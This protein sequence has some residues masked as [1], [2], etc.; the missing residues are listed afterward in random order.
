M[1]ID[2][3]TNSIPTQTPIAIV[4]MDCLFPDAN[5]LKQYWRLIRRSED[6]V[7]DVPASHWSVDDYFDADLRTAD[8]T[9]CRRG[10]FLEPTDFDPLEFGIPPRLLEATDTAQ[11]LGLVV[12][13]RALANAG[14]GND[15]D[16]DRARAGVILGVTGTL[17]LVIPLGARLGHPHWRRSL[18]RAG[19]EPEVARRVVDEIASEYVDWQEGSFPGLLGNVV[20]GRIA[21]RLNLKGTNCVV[22]AACASSL[23]AMHLAAL[24]LAAGRTDMVLTGGVDTFNDVFM[25]MCFSKTQALSATGDARPFAKEADGTVIGEGIGMLVLKRLADAERDGD[26]IHG[27]LKGIGTSSDGRSQS[28]YAPLAEGQAVALH[29]AYTVSDVE[30]ATIE[31]VEAHGTGTKVGDVVEFN[32]LHRVHGTRDD[33]GPRCAIGSVKSQIGHTKAAAGAASLIKAVLALQ[34]R[35][36]PATIKVDQPNP[37]MAL[38]DSPFYVAT[39]SRPWFA[40]PDHPR[41]AAV[42]SF[43]FGGSNFHA[44]VEEYGVA[45]RDPAWDGS[46]EIIALSADSPDAIVGALREW[47]AAAAGDLNDAEL[48]RRAADSRTAFAPD[49]PYR[50][51]LVHERDHELAQ[52]LDQ[53]VRALDQK[54][55]DCAWTLG[56]VFF[57]GPG[58]PGEV[59]FLFP[60]QGSQYTGMGRDAVVLFPEAHDAVARASQ[61]DISGRRL[62]EFIYPV[63]T[64]SDAEREA[65]LAALTQTQVAQPAIGAVS[66]ALLRVL[67][68]FG[69]QPQYVGGHSYGE[70]VALHAAGCFDESTLHELSRLRGRVMAETQDGEGAMLAVHAP[71]EDIERVLDEQGFD[72]ELANRNA[73]SQ[74][75]LSGSR[76]AIERVSKFLDAKG[77]KTRLLQVSAAFHS[78]FMTEAQQ[79]FRAALDKLPI[80]A[81]RVPVLANATGA[82]YP[83]DPVAMRDLLASQL[84]RPVMFVDEIRH[85]YDAGV[86][87]FVEVGPKKVLTGLVNS[88]LQERPH[89]AFS[90]DASAGRGCGIADVARVVAIFAILGHAVELGAWEQIPPEVRRSAMAVQLLGINYRA[91]RAAPAADAPS[92]TIKRNQSEKHTMH[93]TASQPDPRMPAGSAS[94]AS[95]TPVSGN[96][97]DQARSAGGNAPP[98]AAPT[99]T[100][101]AAANELLQSLSVL[102]EGLRSMQALQQQTAQAHQR[103]LDG[104]D[105]AHYTFQMLMENHQRLVERALGMSGAPA[106]S[107]PLPTPP[108]A[109]APPPPAA[110]PTW[111]PAPTPPE[112][113]PAARSEEVPAPIPIAPAAQPV[114]AAHGN[115]DT[116]TNA[117]LQTVSETTGFPLDS[118]HLDMDLETDLGMDR[119]RRVDVLS[120][121]KQRLPQLPERLTEHADRF[122]TLREIVEFGE[123]GKAAGQQTHANTPPAAPPKASSSDAAVT[124]PAADDDDVAQVMLEV[125]AELTGYPVDMLELSMDMEADLGIDSIKRLEILS[126]VQR[127]LPDLADVDP[128]YMGS[129]R[130]LQNILDYIQ[131]SSSDGDGGGGGGGGESA[132][133]SVS[134]AASAETAEQKKKKGVADAPRDVGDA[135]PAR[136]LDA[137]LDLAKSVRRRV[138]R[139]Q[140]LA[141]TPDAHPSIAPDHELWITDDDEAL[142]NALARQLAAADIVTRIVSLADARTTGRSMPVGG[143]IILAPPADT[144]ADGVSAAT[145]LSDALQ[146]ARRVAADLQDAGAAGGALFATVARLDGMFGLRGDAR[147][148]WQ[149]GLA[150]LAKTAAIEWPGVHCRALDVDPNWTD[151]NEVAGAI[152]R[153][154]AAAGP[155]EVGLAPDRRRGL[156][157]H[158]AA[159]HITPG[160]RPPLD[161]GELVL[162]TG[163]ARGVTSACAIALAQ[164]FGVTLALLGRSGWPAP[165]PDWLQGLTDEPEIK[166]SLITHAPEPADRKP[167]AIERAYQRLVADREM[168]ATIAQIEAIGGRA[169]YR[170]VDVRDRDALVHACAELRAEFGP[171]RGI[172]HG[173]GVIEDQLIADKTA[174]S[175]QRVY[176]TKISGL[177]A[178]LSATSD[179]P[180][181]T[182][183]LFSSVA[184]RFGNQGQVDYAIANEVLNKL[185]YQLARQYPHARVVSLNWGPWEGGMVTP[186]LRRVFEQRGI[187]LI[188]LRAGAAALVAEL[189]HSG[190]PA[191]EVILGG[192]LGEADEPGPGAG[193]SSGGAGQP[194]Q[195]SI[196]RTTTAAAKKPATLVPVF[197]RRLELADNAFLEDHVILGKPVLPVVMMWEWFAHAAVLDN[198]GLQFVGLEEFRVLKGLALKDGAR[199]LRVLVAPASRTENGYEVSV[200]LHSES[201]ET[202]WLHARALV[203]LADTFPHTGTAKTA[204]DDV[205]GRPYPCDAPAAY[206]EILFHGPRLQGVT[207]IESHGPAGLRAAIATA[208]APREWMN[209]PHRKRWLT[210]PLALDAALQ[211]GLLWC[212][213]H[214]G[215][216]G[217]PC[218]AESLIQY[219]D[220]FPTGELTARL[221]VLEHDR[222]RMLGNVV[223]TSADVLVAELRR[224]EWIVDHALR[225]SAPAATGATA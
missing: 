184:G 128:Q 206:S 58:E 95:T 79:R 211:L 98:A 183:A 76:T 174:A 65:Q 75:I 52:L 43:G 154:L 93:R 12:A 151:A 56:N 17:E 99:V 212:H 3:T 170:T 165:E 48:A 167:A 6:K 162:V 153:E 45:A 55:T 82:P 18:E 203:R 177:D 122:R 126:A 204:A 138:L 44:V 152:A 215:A 88:I 190:E 87:T 8:H 189:L 97:A 213:E 29:D 202:R 63:P 182:V 132:E 133:T 197:E 207:R 118:I 127:Q 92:N 35:V 108:A 106:R 7:R 14:Y 216:I 219:A 131:S 176:E 148:G 193:R 225:K 200:E 21:N 23:S 37:K 72:V 74:G 80:Q 105:R 104:Q 173:A 130:T 223:I 62:S 102:Q 49:A 34:H 115:G 164:Q 66:L 30:P 159:P 209:T 185:A 139:A 192:G 27:V 169:V 214:L 71:L 11:L 208:P 178:L 135:V 149:G 188:P 141:N 67:E 114:P 22:D 181:C 220:R 15:R 28:I 53:A 175:F 156:A 157:L 150:G 100:S 69:I 60:G 224:T 81:P 136:S 77:W 116:L 39:E 2:H 89:H 42:S 83:A 171:I 50:L 218:Y 40:S 194:V 134:A 68:R 9:Y 36:L 117:L 33:G 166:R 198:P 91:P 129:L 13:K 155:L 51:V 70:L 179:D 107:A 121:L 94:P 124:K 19:V 54:G 199:H 191:G 221:T 61:T 125:V 196:V 38:D 4:G 187:S 142:A 47:Q 172:V 110:P 90:A 96:G 10:A 137:C 210:D 111:Q 158:D 41:R 186:S 20:A 146:L 147:N 140:D 163:G 25:F 145:W 64:F 73:P 143:L 57:G 78:R 161:R 195:G 180:L 119:V 103:F 16:F 113:V 109:P 120:T 84:T 46:V 26:R 205:A 101:P 201:P 86:R 123:N 144:R 112:G 222:R 85:L 168:R 59:A 24:E 31:L 217:L 32:A 1:S 160:T 5:G